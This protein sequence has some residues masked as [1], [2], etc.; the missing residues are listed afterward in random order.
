MPFKNLKQ[1]LYMRKNKT[2]LWRK[3]VSKYGHAPGYK[4]S[5]K[6]TAKRAAATRKRK[7]G[8]QRKIKRK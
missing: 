5:V 3:W 7:G 8:K 4:K 6:Q 1:E 2:E